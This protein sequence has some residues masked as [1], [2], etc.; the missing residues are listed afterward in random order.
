MARRTRPCPQGFTLLELVVAIV[1]LG[2]LASVTVFSFDGSRSRGQLLV[3][4]M[5]GYADGLVRMKADTACFPARLSA[6]VLRSDAATSLCQVSL[7]NQWNGPYVRDARTNASGQLLL[8]QIAPQVVLDL[9]V[10]PGINGGTAY[11]VAASHVPAEI[12]GQALLACNGVAA[13]QESGAARCSQTLTGDGL[14]TLALR[15]AEV[16]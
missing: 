3:T 1:L 13:G 9:Q 14:G 4:A 16:Q 11:Q 15:F 7:V 10:A 2:V 12:L 6:L 5:Q 8:D